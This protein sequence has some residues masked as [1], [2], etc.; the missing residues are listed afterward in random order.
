MRATR[1]GMMA[2]G[3]LALLSLGPPLGA[4]I[5]KPPAQYQEIFKQG[6]DLPL[7]DA[8]IERLLAPIPGLKTWRSKISAERLKHVWQFGNLRMAS[9][10]GGD[11]P[12]NI[13]ELLKTYYITAVT[14]SAPCSASYSADFVLTPEAQDKVHQGLQPYQDTNIVTFPY[15]DFGLVLPDAKS[16]FSVNWDT[17][18]ERWQPYMGPLPATIKDTLAMQYNGNIMSG[19]LS[20]DAP[21]TWMRALMVTRLIL[22]SG[23]DGIYW[24]NFTCQGGG[25]FGPNG[26]AGFRLWLERNFDAPTRK[27]LFGTDNLDDLTPARALPP[28]KNWWRLQREDVT[29]LTVAFLRYRV[30]RMG[31]FRDQIG[32]LARRLD[33]NFMMMSTYNSFS[34]DYYSQTGIDVAETTKDG[35][36]DSAIFWEPEMPGP[37]AGLTLDEAK[38]KPR[39]DETEMLDYGRRSFSPELKYL[40]ATSY[41]PV[42]SKMLPPSSDPE[43]NPLLTELVFAEAWA[44]LVSMRTYIPWLCNPAT[45]ERMNAFQEAHADFF[46]GSKP[47]ARVALLLS[48]TQLQAIRREADCLYLSRKLQDMKLEHAIIPDRLLTADGLAQ[49]DM[50][51]LLHDEMLTEEQLSALE[52]YKKKGVLIV[53]GPCGT[54]DEWMRPRKDG[55]QRLIGDLAQRAETDK[56]VVSEDEH[57]VYLSDS[58]AIRR[59]AAAYRHYWYRQDDGSDLSVLADTITKSAYAKAWPYLA[60]HSENVEVHLAA[61]PERHRLVAHIVNYDLRNPDGMPAGGREVVAADPTGKMRYTLTPSKPFELAVRIP[62]DWKRVRATLAAPDNTEDTTLDVGLEQRYGAPYAVVQS[63]SVKIYAVIALDKAE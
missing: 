52:A 51:I 8:V 29:P 30:W 34:T 57:V 25:D 42:L 58:A 55:L 62:A 26:T 44:N 4:E 38:A 22:S 11:A 23:T 46:V 9:W 31:W 18:R 36:R 21:A 60:R 59:G 6:K 37:Q 32:F 2:F 16:D 1:F 27:E 47:G 28:R 3:A 43:S 15:F 20:Q 12:A 63:S 5:T 48:N 39:A 61:I 7:S 49:F 45:V 17:Y 14:H 33:P 13:P 24:D 56:P 41:M 19:R 10:Y 40:V 53:L 50:V 54:E 35:R